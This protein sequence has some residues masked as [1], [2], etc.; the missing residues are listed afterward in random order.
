MPPA[1]FGVFTNVDAALR[2]L[3]WT[4]RD[5]APASGAGNL[6][7]TGVA[8]KSRIPWAAVWMAL[9]AALLTG[10]LVTAADKSTWS[11]LGTA[12][13]SPVKSRGSIAA[14]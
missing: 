12:T 13:G 3:I 10:R 11:T 14:S 9:L 6:R 7:S 8:P 2:A 1:D 4:D 5:H